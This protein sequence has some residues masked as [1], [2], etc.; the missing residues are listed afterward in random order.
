M[1]LTTH[2]IIAAAITK[3]IAAMNPLFIFVLAVASHYLSDAIPHWDYE[4]ASLDNPE[5]K[6]DPHIRYNRHAIITDMSHFV[7]DTIV[8]SLVVI[9]IIRPVTM[10]QWVWIALAI[11]GGCLPDFLQGFYALK[12]KFLRPHQRLHDIFHTDIRLG[13]YP[14]I[15]IPFQAVCV[16]ISLAI[17]L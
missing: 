7:I 3:P 5:D 6:E 10:Q 13:K 9:L 1:T 14:L 17:L 2:S 15:G 11:F 12:L 8:G 16:I 4:I